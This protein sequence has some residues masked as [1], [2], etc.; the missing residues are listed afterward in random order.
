MPQHVWPCGKSTVT[1][2]R[3]STVTI[4][5]PTSGKNTSP[6]HV[7]RIEARTRSATVRTR[8]VRRWRRHDD[9]H[10]QRLGAVVDEPVV[11]AR[12]RD[13]RLARPERLVSIVE[14]EATA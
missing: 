7:I 2:R 4:A 9:Q 5:T 6:R 10:E 1:P 12:A 8:T 14:R 11:D 13:E 3:R